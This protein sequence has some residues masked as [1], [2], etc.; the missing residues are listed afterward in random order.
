MRRLIL[1]RLGEAAGDGR[2]HF[3]SEPK[4]PGKGFAAKRVST[5]DESAACHAAPSARSAEIFR[6]CGHNPI[7][8][9]RLVAGEP[10]ISWPRRQAIDVR[11]EIR[12]EGEPIVAV[13][14]FDTFGMD[15]TVVQPTAIAAGSP[16]DSTS[17]ARFEAAL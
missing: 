15:F 11:L 1:D 16:L 5:S 17:T 14:K 8:A 12:R 13:Q 9:V 3:A 10:A 2:L 4:L 6:Y 7:R